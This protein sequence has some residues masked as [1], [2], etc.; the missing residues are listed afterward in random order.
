[1]FDTTILA[2][3][4]FS[5]KNARKQTGEIATSDATKINPGPIM[6]EGPDVFPL[7]ENPV[8]HEKHRSRQPESPDSESFRSWLQSNTPDHKASPALLERVKNILQDDD[9]A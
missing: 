5:M 4:F 9:K 2:Q 7:F 8:F 1:M 3:T 6:T